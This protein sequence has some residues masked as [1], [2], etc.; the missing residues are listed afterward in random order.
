MRRRSR[1]VDGLHAD[2]AGEPVTLENRG[3]I[4]R[5]DTSCTL[6]R[7]APL[8]L[9]SSRFLRPHRPLIRS[10]VVLRAET[11]TM[12][13]ID[14]SAD[15][16]NLTGSSSGLL[17]VEPAKP[18]RSY[19]RLA[20]LDRAASRKPLT[21]SLRFALVRAIRSLLLVRDRPTLLASTRTRLIAQPG[22]TTMGL[23]V[24]TDTTI[25]RAVLLPKPIHLEPRAASLTAT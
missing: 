18:A 10:R 16:A 1:H 24:R 6:T 5:R 25:T 4:H 11:L 2:L 3:A 19:A 15:R 13:R 21:R 22:F 12:F 17:I 14:A 7:A 8:R 9:F 20:S 23:V